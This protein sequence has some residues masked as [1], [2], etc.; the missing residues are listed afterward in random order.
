MGLRD[1]T[2]AVRHDA[3][4]GSSHASEQV[5]QRV[6]HAH[7]VCITQSVSVP[8]LPVV[9]RAHSHLVYHVLSRYTQLGKKPASRMPKMT[10]SPARWSHCLTKPMP[11]V[12]APQRTVMLAR[13]MRGPSLRTMTVE[14]GWNAM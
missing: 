14:G 1:N 11:I 2:Y 9:K 4:K 13:W 6:S 5:E 12:H 8:A 7:F 10:R 3:R